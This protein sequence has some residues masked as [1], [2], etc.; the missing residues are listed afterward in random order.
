MRYAPLLALASC[1]AA[2][3]RDIRRVLD[4]QVAAW[5]RG[6]LEAFMEG[7]WKSEELVFKSGDK[8]HRGWQA[9]L[10]RYRKAY[11][12]PEKMGRLSFTELQIR[13]LSETEAEVAGGWKLERAKDAPS[14]TF[15]LLFRKRSEGWRI[16]R[17]ET[18]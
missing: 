8:E 12:S 15:V 14:G 17:D 16:V 9:T 3:E 1:A 4:D 13:T 6:D 10:D 5:N 2:P 7:Y 18:R 11:D